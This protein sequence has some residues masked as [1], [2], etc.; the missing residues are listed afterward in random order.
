M[1]MMAFFHVSSIP[2]VASST[3]WVTEG[4][5]VGEYGITENDDVVEGA[6]APMY[7]SM[8][9]DS[10]PTIKFDHSHRMDCFNPINRGQFEVPPKD[11]RVYLVSNRHILRDLLNTFLF[12]PRP[13]LKYDAHLDIAPF[14]VTRVDNVIVFGAMDPQTG[15]REY[16]D[17]DK[18]NGYGLAFERM[19]TTCHTEDLHGFYRF[20]SF[21][22]LNRVNLIVRFEIDAVDA[23]GHY[24]EI[25]TR[26][27]H[28]PKFTPW[29]DAVLMRD[30]WSQMFLG[31]AHSLVL[32]L[33]IDLVDEEVAEV[34]GVHVVPADE[35]LKLA[36]VHVLSL[37]R[38]ATLLLWVQENMQ[39][40]DSKLMSYS[41]ASG[42]FSLH[43]CAVD[44]NAGT[45]TTPSSTGLSAAGDALFGG[46]RI[47]DSDTDSD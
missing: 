8:S 4:K 7:R 42:L 34:L 5:I 29:Q 31:L 44:D 33:I 40:G 13:D 15:P 18:R 38:F 16:L 3:P 1:S 20:N 22:L 12:A 30:Y 46:L 9:P 43:N 39:V 11:K 36:E 19:V 35:V 2:T 17:E 27:F 32:G 21:T 14:K 37:Q 24:Y 45:T 23:S 10:L 41:V 47:S 25:K 26:R 6:R 28:N